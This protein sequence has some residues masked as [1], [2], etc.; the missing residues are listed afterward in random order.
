MWFSAEAL[1][2]EMAIDWADTQQ[3]LDLWV[4][5]RESLLDYCKQEPRSFTEINTRAGDL[6]VEHEAPLGWIERLDFTV[7]KMIQTKDK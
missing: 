6:V 3:V 1:G 2:E 7:T 4:K 5:L